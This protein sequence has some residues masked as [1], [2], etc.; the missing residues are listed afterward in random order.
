[1]DLSRRSFLKATGLG[2][3]GLAL[4]SLG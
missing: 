3:L 4:S 1:M 2:S